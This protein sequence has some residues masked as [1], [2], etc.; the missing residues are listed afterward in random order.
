LLAVTMMIAG[1]AF[2]MGYHGNVDAVVKHLGYPPYLLTI[3]GVAKVLGG[4][5]ILYGRFPTLKEWAYAGYA[6]DLAGAVASY[7]FIGDGRSMIT[8]FILLLLVL[9]SYRQWKTGWM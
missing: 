8:P 3:L 7:A 5:A 1:V 6:F 9:V 4:A 2:L